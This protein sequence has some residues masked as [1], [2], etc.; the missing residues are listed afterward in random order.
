MSAAVLEAE[1]QCFPT[2][3]I[4]NK[5]LLQFLNNN[6]RAIIYVDQIKFIPPFYQVD[7]LDIYLRF[8]LC[9]QLQKQKLAHCGKELQ[10]LRLAF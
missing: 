1:E 9:F 3:I 10:D 6:K 2:M 5:F 7:C 8:P 4:C